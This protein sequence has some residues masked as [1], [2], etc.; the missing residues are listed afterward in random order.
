LGSGRGAA[1]AACAVA[2]A[3]GVPAGAAAQ[4]RGIDRRPGIACFGETIS[5]ISVRPQHARVLDRPGLVRDASERVGLGGRTTNDRV[6]RNFLMLKDGGPCSELARTESERILRAQP[7]IADAVVRAVPDG[8][9][10]VRIEVETWDELPFIVG[11]SWRGIKPRALTLGN[12]NWRGEGIAATANYE[13]RRGYRLG[14]GARYTDYQ[15]F[16]R[17]Y[18]LDLVGERDPLGEIW[19]AQFNKPFLTDL[20]RRAFFAGVA[21]AHIYRGFVR[22]EGDELLFDAQLTEWRLAWVERL[23]SRPERLLL[24]AML[25][26]DRMEPGREVVIATDSGPIAIP[27]PPG[28][29]SE[30]YLAFRNT[31]VGVGLGK[32]RVRY[33]TVRGYDALSAAQDVPL[34]V[35]G[36]L[37]AARGVRLLGGLEEDYHV[38]AQ[39]FAAFGRLGGYVTLAYQGEGTHPAE[40]GGWVGKVG[41]GRAA[42][43]SRPSPARTR[44]LELNY[45]FAWR[46][47][48]P[49]QLTLR[50]DDGGLRGFAESNAAGEQRVVARAEERVL[51][52]TPFRWT[53]K[54][55]LAV[56]AFADAGRLWAGDAPFGRDTPFHGGVGVS[57]LGAYPRGSQRT[58]RVDVAFPVSDDPR[59]RWEL[60]FSALDLTRSLWREP[61]DV[62]RA[63]QGGLLPL[64]L[65][66]R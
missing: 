3:L 27:P 24:G 41:H 7:F 13:T 32:R 54:A 63:R 18:Q 46:T 33:L 53:Q 51:V 10:A 35:Q 56:A 44:T 25:S 48:L 11:G 43:Y 4:Q 34:G 20:Q 16:G 47:R 30:R 19:S 42:W 64:Q 26:G 60:R 38:M 59:A 5:G 58:Y 52:E 12:G 37:G 50:D 17:P 8:L 31:R 65:F 66:D 29:P 2:C 6:I 45:S 21:G 61:R 14:Y 22:P 57:L 39:A 9:G 28:G 49:S 36:V 23:G 40:R 1:C 62:T 15:V 55:D